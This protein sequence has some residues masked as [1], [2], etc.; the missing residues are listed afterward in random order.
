MGFF[1]SVNGEIVPL[2]EA[3][4]PV[5]DNGF[6]FGD[7]VYEVLRTYGIGAQI[8]RDL[9]LPVPRQ[10]LVYRLR[11]A[12]QAAERAALAAAQ[13]SDSADAEEPPADAVV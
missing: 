3:R 8:L 12:E 13:E 11:R 1:A 7:S 6:L 4:V 5:L 10:A 9:G 2:E